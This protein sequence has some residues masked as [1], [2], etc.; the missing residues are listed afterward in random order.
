M[1]IIK[2]GGKMVSIEPISKNVLANGINIK[3]WEWEGKGTPI[4]M[5]HPS[6]GYGRMWD[7]TARL[8]HPDFR[9]IAP[10][11]RGHGDTD[12]PTNGYS[13]EDYTADL[14]ALVKVLGLKKVILVGFSLGG[15]VAMTYAA[16]YSDDVT[17]IVL[18][19]GPHYYNLFDVPGEREKRA[20]ALQEFRDHKPPSKFAS[21]DQA[22]EYLRAKRP[23]WSEEAIQYAMIYNV[24]R[25]PD[26]SL[27]F[28]YDPE[29]EAMTLSLGA[30]DLT[31]Y[32]RRIT[33]P[34]LIARGKKSLQLTSGQAREAASLFKNCRI[35]DVEGAE[36][37]VMCENPPNLAKVIRDFIS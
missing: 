14:R 5:L 20:N 29:K 27:E 1:E 15:R 6:S 3:Y 10:D 17:H 4:I 22:V 32:V 23:S 21:Q 36:F 34:V 8:L 25:F 11:Q 35:V 26:G 28:K 9:I 33:C 12:R 16:L 18:A 37:W 24:N 2:K 30:V 13:G 31:K 19:G 7:H